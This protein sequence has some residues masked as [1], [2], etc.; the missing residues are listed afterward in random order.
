MKKMKN[1]NFI[2]ILFILLNSHISYS[3]YEFEGKEYI[4]D[5]LIQKFSLSKKF[6]NSEDISNRTILKYDSIIKTC[7]EIL[8]IEF[9]DRDSKYEYKLFKDGNKKINKYFEVNFQDSTNQSYLKLGRY[10]KTICFIR[11]KK[12][13]LIYHEYIL[14]DV[15]CI[16]GI[17]WQGNAAYFNE[18]M[19]SFLF[20]ENS[21]TIFYNHFETAIIDFQNSMLSSTYHENGKFRDCDFN[22]FDLKEGYC[23]SSEYS[24]EFIQKLNMQVEI[25]QSDKAALEEIYRRVKESNLFKKF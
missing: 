23:N 9:R 7:D 14:D 2:L 13:I 5:S 25:A 22:R 10:K 11:D 16:A 1:T 4:Y 15:Y 3:Q 6:W 12:I 17:N 8:V 20:L 21:T 19:T 18:V 24:T